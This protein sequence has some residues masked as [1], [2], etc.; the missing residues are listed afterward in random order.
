[1]LTDD[2]TRIITEQ[3][4]G[5]VASIGPDG[6]PS[7][8]PKGSFVVIDR[9]T[10]AFGE[11]RSPATVRNVR[12]DPRVE[13]TFV[14]PFVRKGYRFSGTAS[15][16]ARGEA[17]FESMHAHFRNSSLASRMRAIV[18][19]A[20]SKALPLTSP[21]Y[22]DGRVEDEVRRSW[23]ARFRKLQPGEQFRE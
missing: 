4:L 1:M 17:A 23:T 22:D 12:V 15:V 8:S 5:F 20:I 3:P 16:I 6:G 18:V 2:M 10:I 21:I 19:I 13:V 14:D 9:A 11:I 7:V